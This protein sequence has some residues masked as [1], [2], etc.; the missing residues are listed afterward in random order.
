MLVLGCASNL[1]RKQ[2]WIFFP[3]VLGYRIPLGAVGGPPT[4]VQRF[5]DLVLI[6][7][8]QLVQLPVG[9]RLLHRPT[10]DPCRASRLGDRYRCW[11][12]LG[13]D[14][15]GRSRPWRR[16]AVPHEHRPISACLAGCA[17][18]LLLLFA[19][20]LRRQHAARLWRQCRPDAWRSD[21]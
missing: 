16:P 11:G 4:L 8:P 6:R 5:V 7:L 9:Q 12:E 13:P 14:G 2:L 21:A 10:A 3:I 20:A 17:R 15:G 18:L 19:G 1:A